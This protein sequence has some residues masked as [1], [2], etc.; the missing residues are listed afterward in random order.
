MQSAHHAVEQLAVTDCTAWGVPHS[1]GVVVGLAK[2]A[3]TT[4][5]R[6][7]VA[8]KAWRSAGLLGSCHL[9]L[10]LSVLWWS[11]AVMG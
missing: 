1:L 9:L 5:T 4:D 3:A 6:H 2:D 10:G 7:D 8:V 11:F